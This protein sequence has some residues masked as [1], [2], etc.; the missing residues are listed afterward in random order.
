MCLLILF[1]SSLEN[2]YSESSVYFN[3]VFFFLMLSCISSLYILN[4]CSLFDIFLANI[5]YHSVDSILFC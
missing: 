4:I 3:C 5:Y 1:M 2:S